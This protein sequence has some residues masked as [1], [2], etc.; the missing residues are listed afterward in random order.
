MYMYTTYL[1]IEYSKKF[2]YLKLNNACSISFFVYIMDDRKYFLYCISNKLF[3][4]FELIG[5]TLT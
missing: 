5:N 4:L 3:E 1:I 2:P